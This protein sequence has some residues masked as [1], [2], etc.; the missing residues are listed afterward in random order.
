[1]RSRIALII[2]LIGCLISPLSG[3]APIVNANTGIAIV[4]D[5]TAL[6]PY[7]EA[8]EGIKE[9]VGVGADVYEMR[10]YSA[11]DML[12]VLEKKRYNAVAVIG[13]ESLGALATIRNTPLISCMVV[14]PSDYAGHSQKNISGVTMYTP[15]AVS[16]RSLRQLSPAIKRVG[17]V[18]SAASSTLVSETMRDAESMGIKIMAKSID[19]P[20]QAIDAFKSLEGIVDA[21]LLIPDTTA[22][23]GPSLDYVL[24]SSFRNN[25]PVVGLS[26]K[27]V[28]MGALMAISFDS[29]DM[30]R[31]VG[32]MTLR[33]LDGESPASLSFQPPRRFNIY[34]NEKTLESLGLKIPSSLKEVK[35]YRP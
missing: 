23:S 30:G 31:Q 17:V 15:P 7:A 24:L 11:S 34:V 25:I 3:F 14:N 28:K 32:D 29:K 26:F 5:D 6:K 8:L 20:G 35:G 4:V 27:Y 18:Y 10:E 9:R 1:M 16:L 22:L 13:P 19:S 12:R 33:I 21:I 2:I